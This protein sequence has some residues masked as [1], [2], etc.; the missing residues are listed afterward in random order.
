MSDLSIHMQGFWRDQ[1]WKVLKR[2]LPIFTMWFSFVD[3]LS[4]TLSATTQDTRYVSRRYWPHRVSQS[5]KHMSAYF[6][7]KYSWIRSWE[8]S[9]K[10]WGYTLYLLRSV[11]GQCLTCS[12]SIHSK[13][14]STTSYTLAT[15]WVKTNS[16]V[17]CYN[18][19]DGVS[20]PYTVVN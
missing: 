5:N 18:P 15:P 4:H 1:H 20:L 13:C 19:T 16:K 6:L 9:W 10:I 7:V 2:I 11:K 17:L 12:C 3:D 14:T 8:H